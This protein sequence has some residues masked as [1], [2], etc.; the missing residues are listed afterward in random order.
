MMT[1]LLLVDSWTLSKIIDSSTLKDAFLSRYSPF[2][3][4]LIFFHPCILQ[5]SRL[6]FSL[7]KLVPG[8]DHQ[9][10]SGGRSG[11]P[12]RSCRS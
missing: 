3:F 5:L 9:P 4:F 1:R 2:P 7:S 8:S 12:Q 10:R 6:I 11:S